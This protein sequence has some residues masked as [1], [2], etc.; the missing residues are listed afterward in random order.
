MRL[1]V[2]NPGGLNRKRI[3]NRHDNA[4]VQRRAYYSAADKLKIIAAVDKKGWPRSTSNRTR[5]ARCY[6]YV[7][8]RF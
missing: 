6:R 3:D 2:Y 7:T 5:L 1:K 8:P 4:I